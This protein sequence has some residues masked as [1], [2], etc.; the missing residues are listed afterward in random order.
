MVAPHLAREGCPIQGPDK[1]VIHLVGSHDD[2]GHSLLVLGGGGGQERQGSQGDVV[3][4]ARQTALIITVWAETEA[5][6]IHTGE[7]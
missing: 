2:G 1:V 7:G 3:L 6:D 5:R 4:T